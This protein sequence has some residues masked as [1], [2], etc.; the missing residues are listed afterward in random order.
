MC[1]CFVTSATAATVCIPVIIL[2]IY[3]QI[4]S[5][6][7]CL[8]FLGFDG[9][10]EMACLSF[11]IMSWSPPIAK[12]L[13]LSVSSSQEKYPKNIFIY[14][15]KKMQITA[16]DEYL[17]VIIYFLRFPKAA[18]DSKWMITVEGKKTKSS[19]FQRMRTFVGCH[20]AH[21]CSFVLL[22][23]VPFF[24]FN[25]LSIIISYCWFIVPNGV[26]CHVLYWNSSDRLSLCSGRFNCFQCLPLNFWYA[27]DLN[28]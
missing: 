5:L 23:A 26:R 11:F 3:H 2:S 18:S 20:Q 25:C 7:G 4:T 9:A 15:E 28:L 21:I 24:P 14:C 19:V 17:V 1:W 10:H 16:R 8:C 22:L 27:V 6:I 12:R 13:C